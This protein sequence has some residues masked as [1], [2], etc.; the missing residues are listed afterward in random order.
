MNR[1]I[2]VAILFITIPVFAGQPSEF[3]YDDKGIRDPFW[4]LVSPS[5]TIVSYG[6]DITISD[7]VLEGIVTDSNNTSIAIINGNVVKKQDK[8][9][10]YFIKEIT[11]DQVLLIKDQETFT[12]LLPK[13]GK[14]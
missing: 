1:L 10:H 7:M 14:Q 4:P 13:G 5:G 3:V 8:V 9:G 12:L 6:D 11:S 2:I